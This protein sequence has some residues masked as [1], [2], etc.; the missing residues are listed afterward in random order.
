MRTPD[1]LK[2]LFAFARENGCPWIEV[3]GVKLPVPEIR[4]Q[5]PAP[6][7]SPQIFSDP[8][9]EYTD[10]EILFWSTPTFDDLQAKKE[11]K[12]K[13]ADEETRFRSSQ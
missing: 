1:E 2:A 10:E 8:C 5:A 4:S 3:D 9:S 7:E 13:H 11:A 12:T 6:Q